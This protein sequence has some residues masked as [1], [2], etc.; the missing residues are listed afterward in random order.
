MLLYSGFVVMMLTLVFGASSQKFHLVTE[1]YY[2]EELDYQ[3]KIY[4]TQNAKAMELPLLIET[5]MAN[6]EIFLTFP[7]TQA[8]VV[9]EV[10]FYK[11]DNANEDKTVVL[12]PNSGKQTL[13]LAGM[14]HGRWMMKVQWESGGKMFYQEEGIFIP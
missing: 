7:A 14:R 4:A 1:D 2:A 11:P 9:G 12:K 10:N 8:D 6:K 5:E 13:S 3:T